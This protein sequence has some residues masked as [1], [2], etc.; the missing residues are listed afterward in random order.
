MITSPHY[1]ACLI[2]VINNGMFIQVWN[3]PVSI[4]YL[5]FWEFNQ[6]KS[7]ERD[8]CVHFPHWKLNI[9][10][11]LFEKEHHQQNAAQYTQF[12]LAVLYVKMCG[13]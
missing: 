4:S 2:I 8:F 12:Y 3:K 6:I 5:H 10:N 11:F 9:F 1:F 7:Q 13:W